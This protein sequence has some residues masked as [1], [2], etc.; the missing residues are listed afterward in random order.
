MRNIDDDNAATTERQGRQY[1]TAIS[2]STIYVDD[3]RFGDGVFWLYSISLS[4]HERRLRCDF[5]TLV[6]QITQPQKR[7]QTTQPENSLMR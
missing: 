7:P 2:H 5:V 4:T 3:L 6:M 1:K